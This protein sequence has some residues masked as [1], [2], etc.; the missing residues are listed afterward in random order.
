MCV[1]GRIQAMVELAKKGWPGNIDC[2]MCGKAETMSH[3]L[4][5]CP[6]AHFCWW[7]IREAL[8]WR[9]TPRSADEFVNLVLGVPGSK[10]NVLE[11]VTFGA[12]VWSVWTTRNDFVFEGRIISS[13]LQVIHKTITFLSQW[14][15]LVPEKLKT[16]AGMRRDRIKDK[17][18]E[19]HLICQRQGV[20]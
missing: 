5:C 12:C 9:C 20:G 16:E 6:V 1:R 17:A 15:L 3:L 8:G 13:P 4:F 7:V 10:S 11:W 19:L 2:K 18:R 14:L